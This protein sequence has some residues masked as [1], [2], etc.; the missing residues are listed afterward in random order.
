[1]SPRSV[2]AT[3]TDHLCTVSYKNP[4]L[5][6][7]PD[8]PRGTQQQTLLGSK[9]LSDKPSKA[10]CEARSLELIIFVIIFTLESASRAGNT[11]RT[12]SVLDHD[13]DNLPPHKQ[14]SCAISSLHEDCS[15]YQRCIVNVD[16]RTLH[17]GSHPAVPSSRDW[18][19]PV[20]AKG[21]S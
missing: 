21:R 17:R 20:P 9:F 6:L 19:A 5:H 14:A 15:R 8:H 3:L 4:F 1:M 16:S 12:Q 13:Q 18:T 2:Q 7:F 11:L 10:F